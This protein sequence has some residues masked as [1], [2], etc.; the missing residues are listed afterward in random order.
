MDIVQGGNCQEERNERSL[1]ECRGRIP[2]ENF[3]DDQNQYQS[4][5]K[6]IEKTGIVIY[7]GG[8]LSSRS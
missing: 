7:H 2:D 4:G 5:L 8:N 3:S 6:F 1:F